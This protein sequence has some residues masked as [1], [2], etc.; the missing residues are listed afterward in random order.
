M[1]YKIFLHFSFS[2]WDFLKLKRITLYLYL[3]VN[4]NMY[5]EQESDGYYVKSHLFI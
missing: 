4:F 3:K 5:E 2:L 1:T